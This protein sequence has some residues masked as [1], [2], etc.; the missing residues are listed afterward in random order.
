MITGKKKIAV[1]IIA[2][3]F[4]AQVL[5]WLTKYYSIGTSSSALSFFTNFCLYTVVLMLPVLIYLRVVDKANVLSY[6]KLNKRIFRGITQGILIGSLIFLVFLLKSKNHTIK[7]INLKTDI[8]IILGRIMVGPLEEIPYR[9]FYMQKFKDTMSFPMANVLSSV[10]FAF[11]HMNLISVSITNSV[12]SVLYIMV[13]GLWMGYIF[14][15]SQS[16]WCV[17]I[18][19]SLY[20]IAVWLLL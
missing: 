6:L 13:I 5:T 10:L 20:D 16:L 19:H 18:V 17:S 1:F 15:K 12:F 14:E 9:G 3:L 7:H 2:Q 11:M 4:I 8:F